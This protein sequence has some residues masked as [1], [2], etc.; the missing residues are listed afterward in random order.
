M[1]VPSFAFAARALLAA[2]PATLVT[3]CMTASAAQHADAAPPTEQTCNAE[4]AKA[5]IG[6]R[7]DAATLQ[8]AS[9]AG[10][11]RKVNP[12]EAISMLFMNGRLTVYVDAQG[13]I[14]ALSC[15]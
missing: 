5:F 4:P 10:Q 8:K 3:G 12:G 15:S 11:V 6:Q 7:F 2:V 1:R 14:T 9:G 13:T